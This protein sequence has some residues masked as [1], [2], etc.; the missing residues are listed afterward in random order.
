M[1][2]SKR[3]QPIVHLASMKEDEEARKMGQRQVELST[4]MQQLE[5]LTVMRTNYLAQF[6]G[7]GV[8]I[9][10]VR[11][12]EFRR[13]MNKLDM[14]IHQQQGAIRQS[15]NALGEQK[16]HWVQAHAQAN[17]LQ[18]VSDRC[19]Q[20]EMRA[21]TKKEQNDADERA[22]RTHMMCRMQA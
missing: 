20:V 5:S 2:T 8:Q 11:L 13:F 12:Q 7:K 1:I 4:S 15:Q 19:V 10:A 17:A 18:K 9:P 3:I 22:Q 14:A 6:Q 21:R 16:N